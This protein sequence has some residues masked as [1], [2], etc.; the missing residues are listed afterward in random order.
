MVLSGILSG[1]VDSESASGGIMK[2][3]SANDQPKPDTEP[4]DGTTRREFLRKSVYAAYATPLSTALLVENASAANSNGNGAGSD[5]F[6]EK[7]PEHWSCQ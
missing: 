1:P 6:C 7:H 3:E 4:D 5:R 2:Q